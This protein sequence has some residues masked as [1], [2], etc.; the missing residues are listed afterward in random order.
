MNESISP[1]W[2]AI[3]A[4]L[5]IGLNIMWSLLLADAVGV[6]LVLSMG[7][8]GGLLV[9]ALILSVLSF[10]VG[11]LFLGRLSPG[12]TVK[13]AGLAS[14]IAVI[15]NVIISTV[16]T[17]Q[18]PGFLGIAIVGGLGYGLGILGGKAG[19]AWQRSSAGLT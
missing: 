13:E 17:G 16:L 10:F 18:F 7:P 6:P 15:F 19:E 4:A 9:F 5:I 11:G 12:E 1:K 8:I 3:G 2:L 14:V